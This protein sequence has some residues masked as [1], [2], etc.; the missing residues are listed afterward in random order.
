MIQFTSP[1]DVC[2]LPTLFIECKVIDA[3]VSLF[4]YHFLSCTIRRQLY[5]N[6]PR[7]QVFVIYSL[8]HREDEL[9]GLGD[10]RPEVI[11]FATTPSTNSFNSY[12]D[13]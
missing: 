7:S 5:Q 10:N 13:R 11:R 1:L 12:D 4:F 9:L 2:R 6:N 8:D 3:H